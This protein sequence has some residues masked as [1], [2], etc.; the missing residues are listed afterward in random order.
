MGEAWPGQ[1]AMQNQPLRNAGYGAGATSAILS[2]EFDFFK[3]RQGS[4]TRPV[5]VTVRYIIKH[6]VL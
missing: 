5:N 1:D 3:G 2:T 6:D 4:Q